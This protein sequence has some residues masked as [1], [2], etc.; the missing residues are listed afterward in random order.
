MTS[1]AKEIQIGEVT[2]TWT[3]PDPDNKMF[4]T[5]VKIKVNKTIK[6]KQVQEL[7]LKQPGGRWVN[8]ETKKATYQ[9][10]FGME[11]FQ[12][13][14]KALF[15]ITHAKD[16]S[17]MVMFQGKQQIVKDP[18]TGEENT[19]R[20]Q[21]ARDIELIKNNAIDE[22]NEHSFL[23]DLRSETTQ[24]DGH[25]DPKSNEHTKRRP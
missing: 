8:P 14:E 15:F 7:L 21:N 17:P 24:R 5:Y 11:S 10:V 2:S 6:G 22:S 16:G 18:K 12:K 4:Y 3:S 13:G 9:K 20:E 19:V 25:S 23:C 1:E